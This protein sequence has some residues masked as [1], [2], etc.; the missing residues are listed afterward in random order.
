MAR[1]TGQQLGIKAER[2]VMIH[3]FVRRL[4][5]VKDINPYNVM[6]LRKRIIAGRVG[7]E[8]GSRSGCFVGGAIRSPDIFNAILWLNGTGNRCGGGFNLRRRA[9]EPVEDGWIIFVSG[10]YRNRSHDY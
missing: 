2:L 10:E 6:K 7:Y 8:G 9:V 1:H 5:P 3:V 4:F